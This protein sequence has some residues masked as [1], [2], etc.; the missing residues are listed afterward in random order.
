METRCLA[1]DPGVQD[2]NNFGVQVSDDEDL[3]L[4]EFWE[5]KENRRGS[6]RKKQEKGREER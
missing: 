4:V 6:K 3:T 2:F 1:N 5:R